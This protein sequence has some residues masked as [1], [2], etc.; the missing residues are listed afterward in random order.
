MEQEPNVWRLLEDAWRDESE[1][2]PARAALARWA[3]ADPVLAGF[4]TPRQVLRRCHHRNDPSGGRHILS[5]LLTHAKA[6]PWAAR[7]VL[8]ALTPGLAALSRRVWDWSQGDPPVWQSIQEVD[9]HVLS[10]AFERIVALGGRDEEWV[11]R[12]VIDGTWQRLRTYARAERR[13]AARS[14]SLERADQ[15]P[16]PEETTA[17]EDLV[18][19]LSEAVE[20][21][22]VDPVLA[23]VVYSFRVQGRSPDLLA[24]D[25]GRPARTVWRWLRRAEDSLV[26][27]GG[28]RCGGEAL[29]GVGAGA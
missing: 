22:V 5:A 15:T 16:A 9:Q 27:D 23:G 20:G 28:R 21:G 25:L 4:T 8:Q 19:V 17:A 26:A 1:T 24:P 3:E 29:T 10:L 2:D 6:D 18:A 14:A 12:V 11:A 7:T 13:R